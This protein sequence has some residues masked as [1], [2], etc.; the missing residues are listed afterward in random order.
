MRVDTEQ[1]GGM[2][3]LVARYNDLS[4]F[5]KVRR[6]QTYAQGGGSTENPRKWAGGS[7]NDLYHGCENGEAKHAKEADKM[8]DEFSNV[9]I[10]D[11]EMTL[12]WNDQIGELD[13]EAAMAGEELFMYG[14][15]I[16]KTDR[17]AVNVYVD[18]WTSCVIPAS[19]MRRRGIA[20]L[21]LTQALSV[22][23]P[24]NV[25]IATGTGF[26]PTKMNLVQVIPVPTNP[27]DLARAAWMLASPVFF[28]QGQLPLVNQHARSN[29][30]C[31]VPTLTNSSWQKTQ[32]GSWLGE[33]DNVHDVVHL[34]YMMGSEKTWAADGAALEWVKAQMKKYMA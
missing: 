12:E 13:Y 4:D 19:H 25:Y 18:Q 32:L 22:Y 28:R 17:S 23:R 6:S 9:A 7:L 16:E 27:M 11:Y 34:P 21:A 1:V 3:L 2:S 29:G 31:G 24:V 20:V 26:L 30:Y 10:E 5:V 15:T 8:T 14:P 33:Q